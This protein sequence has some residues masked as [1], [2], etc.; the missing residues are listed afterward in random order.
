MSTFAFSRKT[1]LATFL[2]IMIVSVIVAI[3][4]IASGAGLQGRILDSAEQTRG[5][6]PN[7]QGGLQGAVAGL[8]NVFLGILGM[9]AVVIVIYGGFKWMTASGNTEQVDEA[10]K[11]LIQGV[12]GFA[13]IILAYAIVEFVVKGVLEAGR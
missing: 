12:V 5:D 11:L 13:I 3:P 9:I 8:I 6:L 4:Y 1:L 7:P 10:K 2:T